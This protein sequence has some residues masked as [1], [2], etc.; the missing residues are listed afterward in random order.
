MAQIWRVVCTWTGG[1]IGT[2]Y[3]NLFFN[4]GTSTVQACA[5]AARAF[6]STAY[7]VGFLLPTGVSISFPSVVDT[8]E[9][10]NGQLTSN[11]PITPPGVLTGTGTGGYAAVA[12]ACV[13]WRTGIFVN[14]RRIR[15]RT[16]L[17]PAAATALQSDGTIDDGFRTNIVNAATALVAA[18]PE[19]IIWRRPTSA[20]ASDGETALV[21]A[22]TVTDQTAFLSSRR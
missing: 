10:T 22:G 3:T 15:G 7:S 13:T 5:D 14:G 20:A 19:F 4:A 17:V 6:F 12:G 2:G 18:A 16:F 11:T 9:A 21:A 1:K 8:I